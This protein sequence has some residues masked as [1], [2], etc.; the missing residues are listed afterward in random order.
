M[1]RTHKDRP[2]KLQYPTWDADYIWLEGY[3][4]RKG[5]T[6]IPKKKKKVDDEWHWCS[7]TPS[8][9]NHLFHTKPRR[10]AAHIWEVNALKAI[11]LEDIDKPNESNRPHKYYY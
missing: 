9:W 8:W 1:S 4:Y 11:E 10:R 7:S 2:Y 5:K 3:G 6:T